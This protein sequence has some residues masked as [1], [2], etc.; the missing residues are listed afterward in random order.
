MSKET[1]TRRRRWPPGKARLEALIEEAIV[2]A[3]GAL[4]P[5]LIN[6]ESL[7]RGSAHS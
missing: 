6:S 1:K 5:R 3:Y 7:H 4:G 2:D